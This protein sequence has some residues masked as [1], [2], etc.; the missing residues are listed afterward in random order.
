MRADGKGERVRYFEIELTN[1]M[2]SSVKPSI[3][4]GEILNETVGLKYS[5]VKWKYTQ[6]KQGGG[7]AGNT[8]GGWDLSTN[9][10]I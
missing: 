7:T 4:S 8:S 2:I 10:V 3:E 5:T 6:Q 1:V 9:K